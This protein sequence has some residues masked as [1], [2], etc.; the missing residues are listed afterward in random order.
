MT[1]Y[2][3]KIIIVCL[4]ITIKQLAKSV[5]LLNT[6]FSGRASCC[7]VTIAFEFF[8]DVIYLHSLNVLMQF[9][10]SV[11]KPNEYYFQLR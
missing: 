2:N 6:Y 11:Q 9:N 1:R 4:I 7:C 3:T 10:D 8:H 5:W